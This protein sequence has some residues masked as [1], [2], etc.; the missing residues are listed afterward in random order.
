MVSNDESAE[1][2]RTRQHL[3]FKPVTG[4]GSRGIYRDR[5][6]TGR[7]FENTLNEDCTAQTFALATEQSLKIDD[8]VTIKEA[9]IGF[10]TYGGQLLLPAAR[11]YQG[12]TTNFRT[13]GGGFTPVFQV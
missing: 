8:T 9:D 11:I 6:L 5:N 3:C 12:Q 13:P 7:V 2:W 10:Y 1:L 4:C